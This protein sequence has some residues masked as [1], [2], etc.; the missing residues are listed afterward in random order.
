ML[1]IMKSVRKLLFFRNPLV[2][3]V[4]LLCIFSFS[5]ILSA[6]KRT[7]SGTVNDAQTGQILFGATVKL[8]GTSLGSATD[9]DGQFF[10]QAN[11]NADSKLEF[12]FV[13]YSQKTIRVGSDSVFTIQ[14]EPMSLVSQDVLVSALRVDEF[15]PMAYT[16]LGKEDLEKNNLGQDLPF[17]LQRTPS[18]VVTSDAGAGVGYT[19]I[20]IRG[21]DPTRINVTINGVPLNDSESQGVFWVNTPDLVSSTESIQIQRGVGT[22]TNGTAAFGASINMLMETPP[23]DPYG[24]FT[25]SGGSFNT[26]K[27]NL[28]VGTGILNNG[29]AFEG[30]ISKIDSDG[31]IDR[32]TS[33]LTSYFLTGAHYGKNSVLRAYVFGGKERTYQAW[34]GTPESRINGDVDEMQAFALRNGLNSDQTDN[35]LNGGRNFNFYTYD[36]QVDNYAQTHYQL[37]YS[38]AFPNSW[39]LSAAAHYTRGRGYFEEFILEGNLEEHAIGP[40]TLNGQVIQNSDLIRRRWLDN[41]F[42]GGIFSTNYQN[43]QL[44]VTI[45]GGYNQYFGGHFGEVIW[46]EVAVGS[47]IRDRFYD[48][49]ALKTD[50]NLYAKAGYEFN[51]QLFFFVDAQVRQVYYRFLGFDNQLRNITQNDQLWFFNPKLG[52]TWRPAEGHE[53]FASF[54]KA[55]REPSRTEF[56]ESTPDSRPDP[57]ILFDYELGYRYNSSRWFFGATGYF[58]DYQDQLILT[59]EVNDVGAFIRQ[60]VPDSYRLGLEVESAW[61]V[62]RWFEWS[63]NVTVSRNKIEEYTEFLDAFDE[64]FNFLGQRE[65]RFKDTDI[66]FSPRLIAN[67]ILAVEWKG[68]STELQSQYVGRQFLDNRQDGD[69]DIDAYWL[70][71]L[72]FSRNQYIPFINSAAEVSLLINNIFDH[73]YESNG[74]TFGFIVGQETIREDF[75]YPQAGRNFLAQV[76]FNF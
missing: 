45:G 8:L 65:Q 70:S 58:M 5:T 56:V 63:A 1:R 74:Y 75:F 20:R 64:N 19:G 4:S 53:L 34:F 26:R 33:D 21:V 67:N 12:R 40:I 54:A 41:D 68:I 13:G 37:H 9:K 32:A 72:R 17:M 57:E 73:T 43:D 24:S 47:N 15:T 29:W 42:Y 31:Y 46:S 2:V 76:R 3:G 14:L 7:F 27:V 50:G 52:L 69:N 36:N 23:S 25:A 48:N 51:P 16:T 61:K 30:R 66:S 38:Y 44:K 71:H 39:T 60:N 22:S 55:G 6:Q 18:V 49:D 11:I 62:T 10:F 59:G 28:E 35:L